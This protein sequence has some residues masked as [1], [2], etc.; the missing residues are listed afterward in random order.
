MTAGGIDRDQAETIAKSL[1]RANHVTSDQFKFKAG[2]A[3][4]RAE[5]CRGS[6]WPLGGTS[7]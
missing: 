7:G 3:E 6:A 2:Q 4:V 1:S 5:N